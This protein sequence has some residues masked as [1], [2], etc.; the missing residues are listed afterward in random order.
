MKCW[1]C[2][3]PAD[4]REHIIKQ[5][6]IRRLFGRGPYQKGNRLKRMDQNQR[7]KRPSGGLK[8]QRERLYSL[9][10]KGI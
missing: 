10:L 6:D 1:I 2:G 7:T 5:S 9:T 8:K 4:T 3:N